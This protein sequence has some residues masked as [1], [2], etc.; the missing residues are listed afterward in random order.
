MQIILDKMMLLIIHDKNTM[1]WLY[2]QPL[3][4]AQSCKNIA[5][6]NMYNVV[7]QE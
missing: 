4:R 2:V 3:I 7:Q 6:T 5:V 1:V